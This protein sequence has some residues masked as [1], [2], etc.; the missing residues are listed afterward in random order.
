M[1]FENIRAL[2]LANDQ[3][4][5]L[6][7]LMILKNNPRIEFEIDIQK[8]ISGSEPSLIKSVAEQVLKKIN[9][10]KNKSDITV[11]NSQK[12]FSEFSSLKKE[13]KKA[14]IRS[15]K[16]GQHTLDTDFNT[17]YDLFLEENDFELIFLMAEIAGL[18]YPSK[19]LGEINT[20]VEFPLHKIKALL[21]MICLDKIEFLENIRK[22]FE[23]NSNDV[24]IMA[25]TKYIWKHSRIVAIA[26]IR[27]LAE[28]SNTPNRLL[29]VK[30]CSMINSPLLKGIVEHLMDYPNETIKSLS[31]EAYL[32]IENS[33]I[34]EDFQF[35]SANVDDQVN[36]KDILERDFDIQGKLAALKSLDETGNI[37]YLEIISKKLDI[38]DNPFLISAY[39]KYLGKFGSEKYNEQI[40]P[41]LKHQDP[42]IVA[43][44]VEGIGYNP[45][46]EII[47]T[48]K[49]FIKHKHHRIA[50]SAAM[51]LWRNDHKDDVLYF[52]NS[53]SGSKK[54][55]KRKAV[56]YIIEVIGE[57]LID[58]ANHILK[59]LQSDRNENINRRAAKLLEDIQTEK[60]ESINDMDLG[61]LVSEIDTS[62]SSPVITTPKSEL[63]SSSDILCESISILD[64]SEKS[65]GKKRQALAMLKTIVT[66]GDADNLKKLFNSD[67]L[68]TTLKTG[69]LEIIIQIDNEPLPFIISLFSHMEPKIRYAALSLMQNYN[70]SG[71]QENISPLLYDDYCEVI[72][73]AA[74]ILFPL[75]PEKVLEALQKLSYSNSNNDQVILLKTIS[76][77]GSVRMY[78]L[79][80]GLLK[81]PSTEIVILASRIISGFHE[82]N[83]EILEA[84]DTSN[85]NKETSDPE[86]NN[87][88]V[89]INSLSEITDPAIIEKKLEIVLPTFSA[90]NMPLVLSFIETSTNVVL[91]SKI[92]TVLG[93]FSE[94][95]EVK[96][97]ISRFIK[98][99]DER[100]ASNT[101]ESLVFSS[102][103]F[104][105]KEICKLISKDSQRVKM[106]I[107]KLMFLNSEFGN[108]ISESLSSDDY[109]SFM[110]EMAPN[111]FR[112][113]F[114]N[115]VI[116]REKKKIKS[117]LSKEVKKN[118]DVSIK[119]KQK[120]E[121]KSTPKPEI[122]KPIVQNNP[123]F[124][125]LSGVCI[126]E[127]LI[128]LSFLISSFFAGPP[129]VEIKTVVEKPIVKKA[130]IQQKKK[131]AKKEKINFPFPK[132][133]FSLSQA[134]NIWM[135]IA[136]IEEISK[137]GRFRLFIRL[138]IL[139]EKKYY[140]GEFYSTKKLL[141]KGAF[142]KAELKFL[143]S[144][145]HIK[146]DE[147]LWDWKKGIWK[148]REEAEELILQNLEVK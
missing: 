86:K 69:L 36:I 7:A 18:K 3:D 33:T 6:K 105:C 104:L 124:K 17:F 123:L 40:F 145:D 13:E 75:I 52:L 22:E 97:S 77:I 90:E 79:A 19:I 71:W 136:D 66:C 147:V 101:L 73:K 65:I 2:L 109:E 119:K 127:F 91:I 59:E 34:T 8:I 140:R 113:K 64:C 47:Q 9:T 37:K 28:S 56:L 143:D 45:I 46:D 99:P 63:K 53:S 84:L 80:A 30:L 32:K 70:C 134:K 130:P 26:K 142:F 94:L 108:S 57:D 126:L 78:G 122:K 25:A 100:I 110:G 141:K 11:G 115:P 107:M 132:P 117:D 14:L 76:K 24:F 146:K 27:E 144:I 116:D 31:R 129:E 39:V 118:K 16:T 51:A 1:K 5:V 68:E 96:K 121:K 55:W 38:E 35:D 60:Y 106:A 138:I 125:I 148:T 85:V 93:R 98:H 139:M 67:R 120:K 114:L 23:S 15:I 20:L 137:K 82:N 95:P 21:L 87:L 88:L 128:I 48:L 103:V 4:K 111:H 131:P 83:T 133:P 42:R 29:A 72:G 44:C 102:E 50:A 61:N 43:N 10:L 74:E 54:L 12:T 92:C 81:S 62:D 112:M 89:L 135:E 49:K 41:Y 58:M